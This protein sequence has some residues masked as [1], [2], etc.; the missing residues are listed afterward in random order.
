MVLKK[1]IPNASS[2]LSM[3][4]PISQKAT[5]IQGS[6]E[7]I[8]NFADKMSDIKEMSPYV[9]FDPVYGMEAISVQYC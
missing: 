6:A 8:Q 9:T 3:A 2:L 4:L 1:S 5:I 7:I